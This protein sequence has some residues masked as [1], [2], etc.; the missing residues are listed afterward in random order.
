MDQ[1]D[2]IDSILDLLV[3][4]MAGYFIALHIFAKISQ[5]MIWK[6][7][8]P[9]CN[10]EAIENV[11]ILGQGLIDQFFAA[12]AQLRDRLNVLDSLNH[13]LTASCNIVL[14]GCL[15]N[16]IGTILEDSPS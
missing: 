8:T 10:R 7:E 4:G 6:M 11:G 13:L 12:H 1:S 3:S 15:E 9:I 5:A 16:S 14:K 2:G